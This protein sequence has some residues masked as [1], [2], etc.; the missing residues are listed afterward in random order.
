MKMLVLCTG[1]SCRSQMAEGYL[2]QYA[3]ASV[4]VYSAGIEAHGLN[5]NAVA[6][7]ARDGVDISGQTSTLVDEYA[8]MVFDLVLTVCDNAQENCPVFPSKA[9]ATTVRL[10]QSFPDPAKSKGTSEE[11]A[12]AFDMVRDQIRDYCRE[13][14]YNPS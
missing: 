2:R 3:D 14:I 4:E 11:I 13:I 5:P 6:S 8:A 12:E 9:G 1:N 10:H 7:M